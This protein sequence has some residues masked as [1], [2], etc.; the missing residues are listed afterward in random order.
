MVSPPKNGLQLYSKIQNI[1]ERSFFHFW[2]DSVKEEDRTTAWTFAEEAEWPQLS[3]L[4]AW[5]LKKL[6]G[7]DLEE[8]VS[9][10]F[11]S[12]RYLRNSACHRHR[13]KRDWALQSSQEAGELMLLLGDEPSYYEVRRLTEQAIAEIDRQEGILQLYYTLS[14]VDW[15][16]MYYEAWKNSDSWNA[17]SRFIGEG[18]RA[19]L[20]Q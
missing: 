20:R 2:L 13:I 3:G 8:M 19:I 16:S 9:D 15:Q 4:V 17:G 14:D 1:L 5:R 6:V 11:D 18:E 12:A 7:E 10:L